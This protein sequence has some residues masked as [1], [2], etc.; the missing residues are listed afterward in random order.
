MVILMRVKRRIGP[1]GQVVIPKKFREALGLRS[2]VEVV[3]EL[4]GL[5]E[6]VIRKAEPKYTGSFVNYYVMTRSRK[7]SRPMN[8]EKVFEE[9]LGGRHGIP[10]R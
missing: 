9:E 2:G 8:L 3:V 4:R 5:E 10:R 6:V 1:K 7:L